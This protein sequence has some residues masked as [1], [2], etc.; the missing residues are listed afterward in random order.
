MK[1]STC[2]CWQWQMPCVEFRCL[3]VCVR[4]RVQWKCLLYDGFLNKERIWQSKSKIDSERFKISLHIYTEDLFWV[5]WQA[6]LKSGHPLFW[7]PICRNNSLLGHVVG[8]EP[9]ACSAIQMTNRSYILGVVGDRLM[10]WRL[11]LHHQ[12]FSSSVQLKR[13]PSSPVTCSSSLSWMDPTP[14]GIRYII[15]QSGSGWIWGD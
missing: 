8:I 2:W 13:I 4:A 12:Y 5:V 1:E 3:F 11:L 7:K 14:K 15:H 9:F 6:Q 10:C